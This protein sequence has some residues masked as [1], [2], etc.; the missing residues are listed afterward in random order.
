MARHSSLTAENLAGS[1][2]PVRWGPRHSSVRRTQGSAAVQ[3]DKHGIKL[4]AQSLANPS[5]EQL[6]FLKQIGADHV[7][8]SSTPDLRS[9]EGYARITKRYADAGITVWNIGNTDVH[10]MPEVTLNLPRP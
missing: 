6:L 10:N 5:E 9:A 4:C 7:S 1:L 3:P 2:S 8:V